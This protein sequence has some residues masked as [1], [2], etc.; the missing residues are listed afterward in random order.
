MNYNVIIPVVK[1]N[2]ETLKISIPFIVRNIKCKRIII[3]GNRDLESDILGMHSKSSF[4]DE[5]NL[6]TGMTYKSISDIISNRNKY[7]T[8]RSGWY[9]Q[10]FIKMSYSL[11]CEDEYYLSWDADTI[12][13]N[14]I[15]MISNDG[16]PFFDMK[17]EYNPPYFGTIKK[18]LG[19]NKQCKESFISEHMLFS[20]QYMKELICKIEENDNIGGNKFFEKIL[21]ILHDVDLEESGFSEFE[22]YGSYM[23]QFHPEIYFRRRLRTLRDGEKYLGLN[24]SIEV[25]E[26]AARSYD[27][28]TIEN[29]K[30][31]DDDIISNV[32]KYMNDNE[33]EQVIRNYSIK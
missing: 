20:T 6:F 4:L 17:D 23:L 32:M 19:I 13:L 27:T 25:L 12:P 22:T 9:F 2:I 18:I 14:R 1:R 16:H 15:S 3:I 7:A 28:L 30:K 26:W 5:D 21:N 11:I 33:L 24:P 29:R 31:P 8:N 10:Q